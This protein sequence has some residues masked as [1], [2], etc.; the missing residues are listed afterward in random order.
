MIFVDL[1]EELL[2]EASADDSFF[3]ATANSFAVEFDSEF[4]NLSRIETPG[5]SDGVSFRV[6][7]SKPDHNVNGRMF[8][9]QGRF[10]YILAIG[11][12]QYSDGPMAK[13]IL[14]SFTTQ[15]LK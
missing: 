15:D 2:Q 11:T 13:E 3:T 7:S 4:K 6:V 12:E 9:R 8:L 10:Y 14:D 1:S 5:Q